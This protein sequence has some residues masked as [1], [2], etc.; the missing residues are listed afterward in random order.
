MS[1][2]ILACLPIALLVTGCGSSKQAQTTS[3]LPETN[4]SSFMQDYGQL[5][6]G[7][8][9]EP[10]YVYINPKSNIAIYDQIVLDPITIWRGEESLEGPLFDSPQKRR[11]HSRSA[12][13]GELLSTGFSASPKKNPDVEQT[14]S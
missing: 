10:A 6:D 11:S 3:S 2:R 5:R 8:S 9:G 4:L 14:Y 13:D 7:K 12:S 1:L